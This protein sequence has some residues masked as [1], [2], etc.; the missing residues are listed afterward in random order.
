MSRLLGILYSQ[1]HREP[2]MKPHPHTEPCP[3][4][5]EDIKGLELQLAQMRYRV[6]NP[7]RRLTGVQRLAYV[8]SADTTAL[9]FVT[10]VVYL[11]AAIGF[12]SQV[13]SSEEYEID[14]L[15][16]LV[17]WQCWSGGFMTVFFVRF[18]NIFSR[19]RHTLFCYLGVFSSTVGIIMWSFILAGTFHTRTVMTM[20]LL[21]FVPCLIEMWLLGRAL[22]QI[23]NRTTHG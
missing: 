19:F 7:E 5:C 23:I 17:P 22:D 2:A 12:A 20:G 4:G 10:L 21:Y 8:L 14:F 11:L 6:A 18:V 16:F 1:N 13:G 3:G 9:Q 15:L